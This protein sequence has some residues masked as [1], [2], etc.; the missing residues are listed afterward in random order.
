[1]K[2][3]SAII[4]LMAAGGIM[5]PL[6]AATLTW[7]GADRSV[8]NV[9]P[10][11]STGLDQICVVY[12]TQGLSVGV[13]ASSSADVKWSRFSNL[14]GGYAEELTDVTYSSGMS[15]LNHVEGDMGYIVETGGRQYCFWVV[16]YSK[17]PLAL[18]AVTES[19]EKDCS[20]TML[21]VDGSGDEIVYYTVNGRRMTLDREIKVAYRTLTADA[22]NFQYVETAAEQSFSYLS[23]P[24]RVAA[25]LCQTEFVVTG[26][27]FLK[28]WGEAVEAESPMIQ[29][30]SVQAM[31]RVEQTLRESDNEV[32]IG[33]GSDLGGS[34]SC[35]IKFEAVVTDGALFKEWQLSRY[36]E[37]ED[38][39][40]RMQE[41]SF[42]HTFTEEGTT[43]VRFVC[44][45]DDGAC[46]YYSDLYTVSIGASSLRCPNAF[47]P[48]NNDG[49]NDEWKVSYAS[50]VSFEC[51][52]F[53][54]YGRKIISLSDPSQ[55][56]DGKY[57]GKLVPTGVYY[58]VI[59]ARGADGKD[60]DLSGDIN[61]LNYK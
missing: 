43:Y 53:D 10:A 48:G 12:T 56:W 4:I 39:S 9:T 28:E 14:G 47:S 11:S 20:F 49:V 38:V 37:F 44:A 29:P 46:E 2:R 36:P 58:Y 17:H 57:K 16:D 13:A 50:I 24:L 61:I 51:H 5:M 60:Y 55:G 22:E 27:R 54:R 6:S 32:S 19:D 45:N 52:I 18:N 3:T 26:D 7:N 59:K 25:P 34:A 42:T 35:E 41:L 40:L 31:T 23:H 1:M 21:D 15:V 30:Y 33:G 8:I